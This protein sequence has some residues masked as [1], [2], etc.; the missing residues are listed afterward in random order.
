M[1]EKSTVTEDNSYLE[2]VI[3]DEEWDDSY[4][5][6][7]AMYDTRVDHNRSKDDRRVPKKSAAILVVGLILVFGSAAALTFL[8]VY[9]K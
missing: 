7:E 8:H 6:L 2:R 9:V 4:R 5:K 1:K 3:T